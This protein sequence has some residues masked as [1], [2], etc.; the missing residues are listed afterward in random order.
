MVHV[1]LMSKQLLQHSVFLLALWHSG[2]FSSCVCQSFLHMD[3]R[4]ST[5]IRPDSPCPPLA[6]LT[7]TMEHIHTAPLPATLELVLYQENQSPGV[8]VNINALI[9][10]QA[11]VWYEASLH[12]IQGPILLYYII[13]DNIWDSEN[14]D[15][16]LCELHISKSVD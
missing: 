12:T 10:Y 15:L 11:Q 8:P 6:T 2:V 9:F 1:N 13:L 5:E 4:F 14:A 16:S 7:H 3:G